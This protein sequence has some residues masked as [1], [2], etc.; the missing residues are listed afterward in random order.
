VKTWFQ[1]LRFKLNLCRYTL[2]C[3][4]VAR[5]L[6]AWCQAGVD[7]GGGESPIAAPED[8]LRMRAS[9]ERAQRLVSAH[10][11]R[12]SLIFPFPFFPFFF[13]LC[14]YGFFFSFWRPPP[15]PLPPPPPP[16]FCV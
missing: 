4:S 9:L 7:G 1:S 11:V 2:E 16:R 15:P 8:A 3:H 10:T 13:S 12:G 14:R 6:E 5:E